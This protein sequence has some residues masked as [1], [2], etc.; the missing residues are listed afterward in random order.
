VR[1]GPGRA[2]RASQDSGKD[3]GGDKMTAIWAS[4]SSS[5]TRCAS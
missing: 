4:A 2:R 3:R 1:G 5:A